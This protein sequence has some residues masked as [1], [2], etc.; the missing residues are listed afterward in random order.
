MV[1]CNLSVFAGALTMRDAARDPTEVAIAQEGGAA[2]LLQLGDGWFGWEAD[3]QP[4]WGST[5]SPGHLIIRAWPPSADINLLLTFALQSPK[6]SIVTIAAGDRALWRGQLPEGSQ[7]PIVLP[8]TVRDGKLDLALTTEAQ[9]LPEGLDT[10]AQP[11]GL[12]MFEPRLRL[13]GR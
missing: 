3:D 5:R 4:P 11:I 6:S 10:A 2:S 13:R 8:I 7:V 1:A 9:P 12:A